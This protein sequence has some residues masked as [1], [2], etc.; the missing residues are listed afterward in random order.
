MRVDEGYHRGSMRTRFGSSKT[1]QPSPVGDVQGSNSRMA[2][3]PG[4][5]AGLPGKPVWS[6]PMLAYG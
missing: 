4:L 5:I 3:F 2:W 6:P 1:V